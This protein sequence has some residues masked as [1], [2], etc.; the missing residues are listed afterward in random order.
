MKLLLAALFLFLAVPA[1]AQAGP[2]LV[3]R[4][5][6]L[7][8]P[9]R[10]L[11]GVAAPRFTMVGLHWQGEGSVAF[12]TRSVGGKWSGWRPA[13]PEAEDQPDRQSP[14]R[15]R[16]GW[17]VGNPYWTGLSDRLDV[18][19]TG[20][21]RRVRAYYADSEAERVP[22]R[23]L[24]IAGSPQVI[25]RLAWG[26]NESIRR[27]DPLYASSLH[28]AIV[29]HTAGTNNYTRAE[30]A[31]IVRG[32]MAYHV[33][34]NGWN[35]VGYNFLVDRYGQIFE[36]RYGGVDRNVVGA[37]AQGFNTG[38]VGVSVLG[39]Y[40]GAGITAA[41]RDAL[42]RLLAWRLDVGHVD[43]LS[44]LTWPSGGNGRF[45]TG[46]PVFLR[47]ISGHRDTG[48]TECPGDALYAELNELAG[49]IGQ[50][51]LPKL[52]APTVRGNIGGPVRFTGR[53]TAAL[54][55]TVTVTDSAGNRIAAGAGT[56]TAVDWTW[57]AT[58]AAQGTYAWTM[59]AGP[60]VLPARGTVGARPA[61][62]AITNAAAIPVVVSPNADGFADTGVVS[63]KLSA[64]ATVTATLVDPAGTTVATVGTGSRPAGEQR[65]TFAVDNLGDGGYA[66]VLRARG[67]TTEVTA[68]VPVVVNR[69]LGYVAASARVFSPNG[70]TRLDTIELG[71]LLA[72]PADV[73]IRV[74]RDGKWVANVFRGRVAGGGQTVPW[75]GKKPH[76]RLR[77]G[78]YEAEVIAANELGSVRQRAPF[79]VDTTPPALKL[80][81][82]RP[83][84]VRVWEPA[85]LVVQI[86][87]KWTTIDRPRPGLVP[88]PA[89]AVV[90]KLRV[91]ARDAAGNQSLPLTY[92]R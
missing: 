56:G 76:G 62:L 70:D 24:S 39:T 7:A 17:E 34:G 14:E 35:D 64:P 18:R 8:G 16:A 68:R 74:V 1:A 43:P 81:S 15:G 59:E 71:F 72:R 41:A 73:R 44:T 9:Q 78:D 92:R 86:N 91:V 66:I 52:Y 65:F 50:T 82:L 21:V 67:A 88:I 33:Q 46:V 69:T 30:S 37:H 55:W 26:A 63:F 80:Y 3:A 42:V 23:A 57:D 90:R 10:Q 5:V 85:R 29:H 47:A 2:T 6:P 87:G 28:F 19:T 77:D 45:P 79:S 27:A 11:A 32:I 53:L 84:R 54:P 31:A 75:D 89:P 38:S 25:S 13:A 40:N 61:A 83:L 58:A 20:R 22:P 48:L 36:G 51:G 60:A 49:G 4:D 12:R